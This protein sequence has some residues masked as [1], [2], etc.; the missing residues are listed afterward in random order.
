MPVMI[1]S[2]SGQTLPELMMATV[3][4]LVVVFAAFMMLESSVTQGNRIGQRE[5][6]SQRGRL[7]MELITRELRSQVCVTASQPSITN[8]TN[9]SVS[10][11]DD[12]SGNVNPPMLRTITYVP[13][14][15][16]TPTGPGKI[17]EQQFPGDV[18]PPST[19]F[20]TTPTRT[21]TLLDRVVPIPGVPV[22]QYFAFAGG[23]TPGVSSTP[24]TT[25]LSDT[26]QGQAVDIRVSVLVRGSGSS[27]GNPNAYGSSFQNDVYTRVADPTT[28]ALG[29]NCS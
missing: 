12:L 1:R 29:T 14:P 4:G 28:P 20:P 11:T 6:A 15:V 23:A 8:G 18:M 26:D 7:A 25:P 3:I 10:F 21:V 9:T 22:F 5:D 2:E 24:L 27:N 16:T 19:Q 17:V 13:P